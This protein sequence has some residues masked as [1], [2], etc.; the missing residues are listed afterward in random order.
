MFRDF[1]E[2]G[3]SSGGG[4]YGAPQQPSTP[5]GQQK[6]HFVPTLNT[7]SG[8]HE[9][10][11]MTQPRYLGP[12][13]HYSRALPYQP[14]GLQARPG[15]IRAVGPPPGVRRRHNE[16]SGGGEE[17]GQAGEKQVG[18]CQVPEQEEGADRLPASGDG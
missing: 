4:P 8:S 16:Q 5:A 9:F 17:E 6:F 7:V 18:S 15:V 11:W 2:A 1:G 12:G 13:A 14:Y 10:Q 3:P